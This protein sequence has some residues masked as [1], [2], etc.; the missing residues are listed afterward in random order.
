MRNFAKILSGRRAILWIVCAWVILCIGITLVGA[1]TLRQLERQAANDAVANAERVSRLLIANFERTADAIDGFL[2]NFAAGFSSEW[3]RGELFEQIQSLNLPSSIVQLAVVGPDGRTF[4]SSVGLD[5]ERVDVSDRMHIRV[6]RENRVDGLYI[7]VPIFGRLS[8]LWTIQFTRAVRNSE[9]K[10]RAIL[11]ASYDLRDFVSFYSGLNIS[12]QGM[13][14]LTGLDG[15]VRVRSAAEVGHGQDISAS[16]RFHQIVA[17]RTGRFDGES[18]VDRVARVGFFT[19]SDRYPFFSL[20]AFDQAYLDRRLAPLQLPI[21]ASLLGLALVL[22]LAVAG[23]V[24]VV[25]RETAAAARLYHTQRLEALGR[26]TGG[27]AHDFNNLL[28]IVMGSLDMLRRAKEDRRARYIDNAL[29]AAE[30]AKALTQQLLAFS[31]RQTLSPTV[32]DLNRLIIEMGGM[33]T[34]S[35][36]ENIVV[37]FDLAPQLWPVKV[38]TDQ[39]QIALINLAVNARDAMPNG[40]VLRI[41]SHNIPSTDEVCLTVSDT[42]AGMSPDVAARVFE[43]FFTTK[44]VGKGTGL[45]LAQVHGFMLQLGGRLALDSTPGHGTS[46]S[47]LFPRSHD[48]LELSAA[49][50]ET[51]PQTPAGL[52]VLVVDDNP[53]IA[54]LTTAA[55]EEQGCMTRQAPSAAEAMEILREASF[56]VLLTDIV[57]P[58]EMDGIALVK[59]AKAAAPKLAVVLMTGYSERLESGERIDSELL[60]KP[61]SPYELRAALCRALEA[62]SGKEAIKPC[63]A[64][65]PETG[66]A[67][68]HD[69][70]QQGFKAG[71][72]ANLDRG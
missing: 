10:L 57:M 6:H 34:H 53:E 22:T 32:S 26:L 31:R 52:R 66:G 9:G 40:G 47:L 23:A 56:D 51:L 39:L 55:L 41:Q 7:S 35:L 54:A 68:K 15:I 45:G 20:V 33:L 69:T 48:P 1:N 49:K 64:P 70:E 19:T 46:I 42:G 21:I 13:T 3:T 2:T 60:L 14:A 71:S 43:P 61:F 5:A 58:G 44:E 50:D 17:N 65:Y 29:F 62:F 59:A 37:E 27:I 18:V 11:V 8:N 12:N 24:W 4:V 30:R 16:P 36:R 28:M 38:D 25:G 63:T 67:R 72:V